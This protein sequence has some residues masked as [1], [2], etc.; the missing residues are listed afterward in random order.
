MHQKAALYEGYANHC[1]SFQEYQ[2]CMLI[3]GIIVYAVSRGPSC[4]LFKGDHRVF[5]VPVTQGVRD[6]R[7]PNK[8]STS[9]T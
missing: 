7:E 9:F 1:A 8:S 2:S 4:M 6:C 5:S 3:K